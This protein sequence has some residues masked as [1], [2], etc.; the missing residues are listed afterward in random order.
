MLL[1]AAYGPSAAADDA[2]GKTAHRPDIVANAGLQ[3]RVR[4]GDWGDARTEDIEAVLYSTAAVL[5]EH[6]PGRRLNPIVISYSPEQPMTLFERGPGN[7]HQVQLSATGEQWPRYA[8]EF[9]HELSHILMNYDHHA[10][11]RSASVNQ[12]FE[13]A[14]CEAASLYALK[15]LTAV[16]ESRPPQAKWAAYAPEFERY[17]ERFLRESHR[18]VSGNVSLAQWFSRNEDALRSTPYR[19]SYNE[20]VA[21]L[22]LPIFEDDPAFWDA[23]GYIN[24]EPR[25]DTFRGYLE[26]WRD[27]APDDYK[28]GILH[29]MGLFGFLRSADAAA[30]AGGQRIATTVGMTPAGAAGV[31]GSRLHPGE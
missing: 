19:R 6:F 7:S 5:L 25:R 17:G 29:I 9:A 18:R 14:V 1:A 3:I 23:I 13:E 26:T 4:E 2:P 12:W 16:W 15:R 30:L 31:A 24:L 11:A 22:L 8:Y 20:V 10:G 27:N 28:G 21:T